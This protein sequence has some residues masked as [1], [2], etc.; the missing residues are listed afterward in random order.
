MG[1][2]TPVYA[3]PYPASTD[4]ADVPT[5]IQ[6]LANRLEA[7]FTQLAYGEITAGVTI[8]ALT[9]A[10][11]QTVVSSGAITYDGKPV[12]VEF[13]TPGVGLTPVDSTIGTQ[14]ILN[15]WD[16]ATDLGILGTV[17]N[18]AGNVD[19]LGPVFGRRRLTP[20]AGSHTYQI[21]GWVNKNRALVNAG[22]G[23]VGATYLPSYCRVT[24]A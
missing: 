16:G 12:V 17:I 13:F 19:F 2:T 9:A 3:L 21:K 11:A 8:T 5:D 23:G 4:P 14:V 1:A 22:A 10:A 24:R 6:A 20:A 15:L 18:P 7:L